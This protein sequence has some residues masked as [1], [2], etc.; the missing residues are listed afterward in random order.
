MVS[1]TVAFFDGL[2]E[3]SQLVAGFCI[4]P[5]KSSGA[6]LLNMSNP[7][8]KDHSYSPRLCSCNG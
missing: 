8:E 4:V 7:L 3:Y 5:V 6:E 2:Q 1:L